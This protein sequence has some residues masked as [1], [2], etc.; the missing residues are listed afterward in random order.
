ME[1]KIKCF[2]KEHKEIIIANYY[3]VECNIYMCNKCDSF[4]S[5]LFKSHQ[6]YNLTEEKD[7]KKVFTEFCQEE[8]HLEKLEY[9]C[10]THNKLCCSSCIVK[11]KR[12][13][14]GQHTDC[15]ICLIEDIEN[16][17]KK[18]LN[19]NIEI[20]EDLSKKIEES[21]KELKKIFETINKNKDEIKLNI[22]TIFTKL[23][24]KINEREDELILE[25]DKI[26]EKAYFNENQLKNFN[27]MPNI[28]NE[29]LNNGK[30]TIQKWKEKN[31]LSNLRYQINNCIN[32]ENNILEINKMNEI[33]EKSREAKNNTTFKFYPEKDNNDIN[34]FLKDIDLFGKINNLNDESENIDLDMEIRT[35]DNISNKGI[36]FELIGFEND[37]YEKYYGKKIGLKKDDIYILTVCL[38]VE[39]INNIDSK[40]EFFNQYFLEILEEQ[41]EDI[42]EDIEF[43]IRKE[44]I[45]IFLDFKIKKS[46][47]FSIF[48]D[49]I[50]NIDLTSLNINYKNDLNLNNI[51][52]NN[53][54]DLE[55]DELML[56]LLSFFLSIKCKLKNKKYLNKLIS[57]LYEKNNEHHLYSQNNKIKITEI[58]IRLLTLILHLKNNYFR[59]N[60][61]IKKLFEFIEYNFNEE[62]NEI[63]D[64][65]QFLLKEKLLKDLK[66]DNFY[67]TF[68]FVKH[69][70]GFIFNLKTEGLSLGNAEINEKEDDKLED[71]I[72][73]KIIFVGDQ[74]VGKSSILNRFY[75]DKFE[76]DYQQTI[77]LDFHSKNVIIKGID[78]RLLLY[79]TG[80][81]EKFRSLIPMYIR[82]SNIIIIAYDISN[83]DSFI[84]TEN[85][86]KECNNLS[87]NEV[88]IVLLGNKIDLEVER[89]VTTQEAEDF[90]EKN[91]LLFYEVSAKTG[92]NI[93]ELFS[94]KIYPEM[95]KQYPFLNEE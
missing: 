34:K 79:D 14:K 54:S 5:N 44:D 67:I 28:I 33:L 78:A 48:E 40:I 22:Q 49:I 86:I 23:R 25:V 95:I 30:L 92:E 8:K 15:D 38:E 76:P 45:K 91:G 51:N 68:L 9:F 59:F 77:G 82:G 11:L 83:K 65:M 26:Y 56:G 57:F 71:I 55:S 35:I 20:L 18:N 19:K 46:N 80:G 87:R 6:K 69:K 41:D 2:N 10:K 74:C 16:E 24:N 84:H 27:K 72:K 29:T 52:L 66:L 70:S 21:I 90:A 94:E 62:Y 32:I 12:E 31:N 42:V 47:F 75:Q 73:F 4:H 85:W 3:C 89:K 1:N 37:Y 61:S 43:S 81:N 39:D 13:G 63:K 36:F 58:C 53:L 88:I 64:I 60:Y 7:I 93:Q 17:K 50:L